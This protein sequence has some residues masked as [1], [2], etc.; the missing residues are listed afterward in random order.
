MS[1]LWSERT[2]RLSP[3]VPGEQPQHPRLLK[4]NTN[5]APF[6]PSPRVL[7]ALRSTPGDALRRYP[8][9]SSLAL[10]EQ[11]AARRG[12]SA[13]QV[14][15]GN[16]SDEVLAHVFLGLLRQT[17]P[18]CFPDITYSFYPVWCDLYD[19][20]WQAVALDDEL[21]IDVDAFPVDCGGIILPNPNAP[22]GRL[23]PLAELRRLLKAHRDHV[24]VID[25]AYVD[26][27]GE[28]ALTLIRDFPQLL[29]VQTLS[30]GWALAGLRVGLAFGDPVLIEGLVRVKDSFNSYPLDAVAQRAALAAF[31]DEDYYRARRREVADTRE[32]LA[33]GLVELGF[34]VL[35]SA[36][37]FLFTRPPDGAAGALFSELREEG[38]IVRHFDRPRIDQY[39]RIS[40]GTEAETDRLLQA[41]QARVDAAP[42]D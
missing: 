2:R 1:A 14:F 28:S 34:T 37:N 8:D 25:E 9:P 33:R 30:K 3:Y 26:F 17:R 27:G 40:I 10:R 23:L 7:E 24:V 19:I 39:L 6:A 32:R 42:A 13:D 35:P 12:L 4:L 31:E 41:L 21:R 22:T 16:G 36:A 38:I 29:V 15:V 5:E 18:L 20:A 11:V